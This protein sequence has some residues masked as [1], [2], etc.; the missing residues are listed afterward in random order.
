MVSSGKEDRP[1]HPGCVRLP[2]P[3]HVTHLETQL[4]SM[5]LTVEARAPCT[6]GAGDPLCREP[7]A[8]P[9]PS[10]PRRASWGPLHPPSL[11]PGP[12]LM[13]VPVPSRYCPSGP[14]P[15]LGGRGAFRGGAGAAEGPEQWSLSRTPG[16]PRFA[17]LPLVPTLGSAACR[18]GQ[19]LLTAAHSEALRGSRALSEKGRPFH[20][21]LPHALAVLQPSSPSRSYLEMSHSQW[22]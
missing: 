4:V 16:Q 19:Q 11:W 8:L 13:A 5:A 20:E 10:T 12:P 9:A 7:F 2:P 14:Q 22:H 6:R 1:L 18:C 3:A 15:W 17:R 21:P